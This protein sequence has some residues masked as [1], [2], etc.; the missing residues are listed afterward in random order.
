MMLGREV[1]LPCEMVFGSITQMEGE[2]TS[3][4]EF[5]DKLRERMQKAH[6]VAREHLQTASKR[7]KESFYAKKSLTLYSVGDSIW[8]LSEMHRKHECP[9]LQPNYI[10]PCV[11]LKKISDLNYMIQWQKKDCAS[12]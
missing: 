11:V 4:G 1:R 7:Q 8:L 9:K 12:Q 6:Q 2:V 3:Y 10:G 5:V